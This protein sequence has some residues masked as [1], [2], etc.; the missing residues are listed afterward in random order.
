MSDGLTTGAQTFRPEQFTDPDAALARVREIYDTHCADLRAR[1]LAF[2]RGADV[3]GRIHRTYPY[4]EIVTDRST[5][6]DTRLA[7]GFVPGPGVYRTTVT[8]P[9][10]F[11]AYF[12]HQFD[13]RFA[14]RFDAPAAQRRGEQRECPRVAMY[15]AHER[16]DL[17]ASGIAGAANISTGGVE[18]A[19]D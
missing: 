2:A 13:Q 11:A 5:R 4:V 17:L 19:L 7:Y 15:G 3:E 16:L 8:R 14:G 10:L 1:F 12:R 9:D 6:V 18:H